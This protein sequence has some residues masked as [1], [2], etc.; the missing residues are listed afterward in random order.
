MKKALILIVQILVTAGIF[1]WIFHDKDSREKMGAAIQQADKAWIVIGILF[2]CGCMMAGA[3]RWHVL[4]RAQQIKL[5]FWRSFSLFMIGAFFN[6]F[7]PGATGGDLIKIFYIIREAPDRKATAFFSVLID[8]IIGLV[9]LMILA[10]VMIVWR[11]DFLTQTPAAS[12]LLWILIGILAAALSGITVSFVIAGFNLAGK[13]PE[14]FPMREKFMELSTAYH[15]YGKAWPSLIVALLLSLVVH[16][17]FVLTF[18]SANRAIKADVPAV[19][20]IAI[21]PIVATMQSLPASLSG[22]GIREG[23]WGK[24]LHDLKGLDVEIGQLIGLVC[25]VMIYL[26]GLLGGPIYILYRKSDDAGEQT[27]R[28]EKTAA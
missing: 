11:Y 19:D 13:L 3:I 21:G 2:Y 17:C 27:I 16:L 1:V 9:G 4:L 6:L 22:T 15:L 8:R 25:T 5:P 10:L 14:K 28:A 7:M 24:L 26:F 18:W 20:M 23:I 12:G